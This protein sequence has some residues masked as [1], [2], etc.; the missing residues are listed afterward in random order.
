MCETPTADFNSLEPSCEFGI[1]YNMLKC[2]YTC[3]KC[4]FLC[5]VAVKASSLD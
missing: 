4:Q 3:E 5:G 1:K 2:F